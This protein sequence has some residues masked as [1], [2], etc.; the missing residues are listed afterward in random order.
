MI[1]TGRTPLTIDSK[2]RLQIPAKV[3]AVLAEMNAVG[4]PW[5]SIPWPN[6]R[7]RLYTASGF[8]QLQ[9][10]RTRTA[11]PSAHRQ[12]FEAAFFGMAERLE[13]DASNR[14]VLPKDHLRLTGLGTNVTLVG[15]GDRLELWDRSKWEQE[16]QALFMSMGNYTEGTDPPGP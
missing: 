5:Y 4:T 13:M 3:M 12:A 15:A 11:T 8:A 7:V 10:Q 1:F 6:G 2:G 14:V 16:E 9:A